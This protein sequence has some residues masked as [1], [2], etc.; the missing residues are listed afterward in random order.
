MR[1]MFKEV[2]QSDEEEEDHESDE[3]EVILQG[4][5]TEKDRQKNAKTV[6]LISTFS[7]E[8]GWVDL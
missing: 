3:E 1:S 5:A 2:S 8:K 4:K 7:G 6:S